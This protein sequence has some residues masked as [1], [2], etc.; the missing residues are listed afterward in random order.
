M[1]D[2]EIRVKDAGELLTYI[3]KTPTLISVLSDLDLLP[4]QTL[5]NEHWR[6]TLILAG[7]W[8]DAF[9]NN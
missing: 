5:S 2:R 7:A 9:D 8:R 1:D 4:E 6:K 3:N